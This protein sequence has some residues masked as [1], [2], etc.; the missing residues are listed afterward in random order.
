MLLSK[1]KETRNKNK[2]AN[3]CWTY[4]SAKNF[5]IRAANNSWD[6]LDKL[7]KKKKQQKQTKQKQ[8]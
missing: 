4:S 8:K 5:K 7:L 2:Q 1:T 6:V 3:I